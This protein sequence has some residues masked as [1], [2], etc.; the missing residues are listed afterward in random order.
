MQRLAVPL[1]LCLAATAVAADGLRARFRWT[2]GSAWRVDVVLERAVR[3]S[4]AVVSGRKTLG[5][6]DLTVTREATGFLVASNA[7][8]VIGDEVRPAN[9][10]ESLAL[11]AWAPYHVDKRGVFVGMASSVSPDGVDP[12]MI[13]SGARR[14]WTD[15]IENWRGITFVEGTRT[16]VVPNAESATETTALVP[17]GAATC[18][19]IDRSVSFAPTAAQLEGI[20]VGSEGTLRGWTD[21][22]RV[23]FEPD[24]MWPVELAS[25]RTVRM[26]IAGQR[27]PV[28]RVDRSTRR[29]TPR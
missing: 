11:G 29:F 2:D 27:E 10:L 16:L 19:H 28:E 4:G 6:Y 22:L 7:A 5:S 18:V 24:G 13:A 20:T 14:Q 1:A 8:V 9:A 23:T 21:A 12:S 25:E 17:C 15:L 3:Q 26:D